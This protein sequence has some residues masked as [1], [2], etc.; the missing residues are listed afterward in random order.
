MKNMICQID[1]L[2]Y[3][4]ILFYNVLERGKN[5]KFRFTHTKVFEKKYSAG[6]LLYL[7]HVDCAQNLQTLVKFENN[8]NQSKITN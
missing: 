5:D 6:F 3:T 2:S 1:L 8:A 4:Y 7:L